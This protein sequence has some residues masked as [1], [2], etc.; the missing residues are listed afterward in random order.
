MRL[1]HPALRVVCFL[2]IELGEQRS[3]A[4]ISKAT[5]VGAGTLY[6]LLARLEAAGWLTSEWEEINPKQAGR[7]R[8]KLHRLT[9]IGQNRARAGLTDLQ[10][11]ARLR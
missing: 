4:E 1:T 7:P 2:L 5:K 8:K 9:K 6:P 10:L 3:G 11:P